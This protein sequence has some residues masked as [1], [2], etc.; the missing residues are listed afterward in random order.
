LSVIEPAT[1]ADRSPGAIP[2]E[3][4]P[5]AVIKPRTPPGDGLLTDSQDGGDI[6][7]SVT[8]LPSMDCPQPQSFEDVIGLG[9]S[10]G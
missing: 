6:G 1:R 3:S 7:D 5:A 4:V 8:Q 2:G 9:T 10:V